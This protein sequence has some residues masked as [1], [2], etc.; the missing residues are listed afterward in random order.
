MTSRFYLINYFYNLNENNL[1][2]KN[3]ELLKDNLAYDQIVY[4]HVSITFMMRS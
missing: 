3:I 2:Q 4:Y 1:E